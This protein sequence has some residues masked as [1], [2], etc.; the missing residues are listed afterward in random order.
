M[1]AP[2]AATGWYPSHAAGGWPS[3][4]AHLGWQRG[5]RNYTPEMLSEAVEAVMSGR[6]IPSHAALTYGVPRTT[7]LYKMQKLK[8]FGPEAAGLNITGTSGTTSIT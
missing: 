4:T 2:V 6:L 8:T 1:G 3:A 7:I 5:Q